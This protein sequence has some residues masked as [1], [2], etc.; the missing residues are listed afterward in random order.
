MAPE[1]ANKKRGEGARRFFLSIL[2]LP[3]LTACGTWDYY[4]GSDRRVAL[5]P[6]PPP[7]D[8]SAFP[9]EVEVAGSAFR[10][11]P[12]DI[13]A[14]QKARENS[15]A[16]QAETYSAG[17]SIGD[18]FDRG[19]AL[20]WRFDDSRRM[21]LNIRGDGVALETVKISYTHKFGGP[22]KP[23]KDKKKCQYDSQFQGIIGSAYNEMFR[24][25]EQTIWNQLD[26]MGL[27]V[28]R[29]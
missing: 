7:F 15:A 19:A 8:P 13:A 10:A 3:F 5:A 17:C 9:Q 26:D 22:P 6:A 18:R 25:K 2:I 23:K 29:R 1:T 4:G 20:S 11:E 24:R 12:I 16:L 28:W 27:A 14:M 21:D